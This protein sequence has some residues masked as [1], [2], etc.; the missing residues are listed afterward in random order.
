ME[1]FDLGGDFGGVGTAAAFVD[2][3]GLAHVH[4]VVVEVLDFDGGFGL[5][6]GG[7]GEG[8]EEA[9]DGAEEGDDGPGG[10]VE[11]EDAPIFEEAAGFGVA[12]LLGFGVGAWVAV[13]AVATVT[14]AAAG[15][16]ECGALGV[17][18]GRERLEV[19][20]IVEAMRGPGDSGIFMRSDS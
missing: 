4:E 9:D 19:G 1:D 7:L 20:G 5:V 15:A 2:F 10:F 3:G 16:H 12:L 6:D 17:I 8:D 11:A 18:V 14:A 13:A